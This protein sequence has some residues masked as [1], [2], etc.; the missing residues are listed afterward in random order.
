[1]STGSTRTITQTMPPPAPAGPL[2]RI[3]TRPLVTLVREMRTCDLI[4][5]PLKRKIQDIH[6]EYQYRVVGHPEDVSLI[7][8]RYVIEVIY[9]AIAEHAGDETR[10]NELHGFED[11][12]KEILVSWL[13]RG[14]D[15]NQ[16][17]LTR[18]LVPLVTDMSTCDFISA[19]L[20]RKIQD[21]HAQYEHRVGR[22]PEEVPLIIVLYVTQVI[23]PAIVA[24]T[25]D[26]IH[27]SRLLGFE[28]TVRDILTSRLPRGTN[29]DQFIQM[30]GGWDAAESKTRAKSKQITSRFQELH[31][32]VDAAA[33][34]SR[35]T[36]QAMTE[37]AQGRLLEI[38]A[39]RTRHSTSMY[40]QLDA[41][42]TRVNA[43]MRKLQASIKEADALEPALTTQQEALRKML[44]SG[45]E[46]LRRV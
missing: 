30:C 13:P 11:R 12:V 6:A 7:I 20:K 3:L 16:F 35:A 17:L 31:R 32:I 36:T 4:S 9:P 15:V 43:E 19:P 40:Q 39:S 46:V 34:A 25:G 21:I 22:N 27:Q 45:H 26:E 28:E 14:T 23:H 42:E 41:V 8:A 33:E 1:M 5:E 29:I 18:W 24:H 10:Q 37:V 2:S 38:D 44:A